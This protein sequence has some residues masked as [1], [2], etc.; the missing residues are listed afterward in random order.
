[1]TGLSWVPTSCTLPTE[2]QPLRIA[3]WDQLF[4]ET[5]TEVTRPCQLRLHLVLAGGLGVEERVRDLASRESGCCSFFT[6]TVTP[7]HG[8]TDDVHLDVEV[9]AAH[10]RVLAALHLRAADAAVGAGRSQ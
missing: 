4:T 10:E 8:G 7:D 5:L 6:F 1:M 2:Q 3:E 9:D